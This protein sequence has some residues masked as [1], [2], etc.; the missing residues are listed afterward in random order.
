MPA[1]TTGTRDKGATKR[2]LL[3]AVGSILASEGFSALGINAVAKEAGVDKV[4]IYRYF[5]GMTDLL[6]A[7]GQSVDFW[8]TVAEVLGDDPSE[9]MELSLAD[10]WAIG[11]SRYA[12]ALRRRPVTKEI[13]AWEQIEQNE[14]TH[15]LR[16][17]RRSWFEELMSHFPDDD[18]A[19]EADLVGTVLLI[20]G[21]IHYF[22]VLSRLQ[23]DFSGVAVRS[24]DG[25]VHINAVISEICRGTLTPRINGSPIPS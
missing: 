9:M 16:Q 17:V 5:G 22:V 24:D 14:L 13:L 18:D 11:L 10:R 4:L 3:D 8:P 12:E 2:R 6:H 21:A 1:S 15:I 7:F 20:V 19:T 23:E 25:W